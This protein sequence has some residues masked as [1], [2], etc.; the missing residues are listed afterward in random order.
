MS[1]SKITAKLATPNAKRVASQPRQPLVATGSLV[2]MRNGELCEVITVR[3]YM[4]AGR[5]AST[6]KAC[7]WAK[8]ADTNSEWRSGR[9]DAGGYGYHKGSA[10]IADAVSAAGFELFGDP[11]RRDSARN[12]ERLHFG[13]TGSSAYEEIFKAI[14]R[15]MGYRGRMVWVSH[16]L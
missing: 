15:A 14:A 9:G 11:Y 8:A 5:N 4:S 13:G 10:A 6:V 1:T 16:A 2:A 3:T 7:V 12:S